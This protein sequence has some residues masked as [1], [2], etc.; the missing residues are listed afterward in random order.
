M[1]LKS[2][3]RKA[4]TRQPNN[5]GAAIWGRAQLRAALRLVRVDGDAQPITNLLHTNVAGRASAIGDRRLIQGGGV[6]G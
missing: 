4:S 2:P 6:F 3:R 5:L 1:A